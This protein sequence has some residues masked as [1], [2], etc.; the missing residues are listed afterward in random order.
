MSPSYS[1]VEYTSVTQLNGIVL[2]V[3]VKSKKAFVAATNIKLDEKLLNQE[4]WFPLGNCYLTSELHC[5]LTASRGCNHI[6]WGTTFMDLRGRCLRRGRMHCIQN[7]MPVIPIYQMQLYPIPDLKTLPDG[8]V[9]I[10]L[11]NRLKEHSGLFTVW[12]W[13]YYF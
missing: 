9:W 5:R 8:S 1:Q 3:V 4:L 11:Q 2:E 6:K 13:I 10:K 12:H 7:C